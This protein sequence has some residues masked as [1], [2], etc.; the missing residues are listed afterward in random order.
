MYKNLVNILR[1]VAYEGRRG[2]FSRFIDGD[3]Y[4]QEMRS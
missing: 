3:D 4:T 1:K 2:S